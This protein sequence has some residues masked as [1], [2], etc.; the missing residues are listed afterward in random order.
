MSTVHLTNR[1][2]E[3][4]ANPSAEQLAAALDDFDEADDDAPDCW[5]SDDSG[6]TVSIFQNGNVVLQ[7]VETTEG[8]WHVQVDTHPAALDLWKLLQ[9]G[10]IAALRMH[11]SN[12]G[13]G[14]I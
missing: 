14:E 11:I 2:G 8:P 13:I 4:F 3:S 5:L 9:D 7:N 6:W 12:P 1:W 10:D